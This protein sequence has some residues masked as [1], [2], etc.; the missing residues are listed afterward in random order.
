MCV[1]GNRTNELFSRVL[2]L[3]VVRSVAVDPLLQNSGRLEHHDATRGHRH[4]AGLRI[5][6]DAPTFFEMFLQGSVSLPSRI[7]DPS[8][9]AHRGTGMRPRI[10][11]PFVKTV[12]FKA[13]QSALCAIHPFPVTD[14]GRRERRAETRPAANQE[15]LRAQY[16][17]GY[18]TAF[19]VS[20]QPRS[21]GRRAALCPWLLQIP[22]RWW[23]WVPA[24]DQG[25]RKRVAGPHR[26]W[27]NLLSICCQSIRGGIVPGD[28]TMRSSYGA[29]PSCRALR[30]SRVHRIPCP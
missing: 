9:N 24:P 2:P 25:H 11:H 13:R 17:S 18:S 7:P 10:T 8:V 28:G 16:C 6:A 3:S 22:S 19:P 27:L 21:R 1:A 5:A 14:G 20:G 29:E 30:R 12:S 26:S 15:A 23:A 4:L